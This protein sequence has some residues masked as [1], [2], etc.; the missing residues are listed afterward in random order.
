MFTGNAAIG[1]SLGNTLVFYV[2]TVGLPYF[3]AT[4]FMPSA[5]R[6]CQLPAPS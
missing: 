2:A 3:A 5:I 4:W 6:A 1:G